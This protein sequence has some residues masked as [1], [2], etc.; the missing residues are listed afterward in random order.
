MTTE[1]RKAQ[2]RASQQRYR[3]RK[4]RQQQKSPIFQSVTDLPFDQPRDMPVQAGDRA[5]SASVPPPD[6]STLDGHY[7][8]ASLRL[9]PAGA[10]CAPIAFMPGPQLI[11]DH[12]SGS[13]KPPNMTTPSEYERENSRDRTDTMVPS[14]RRVTTSSLSCR[15]CH[16]YRR[17]YLDV[18][19]CPGISGFLFQAKARLLVDL[20][21]LHAILYRSGGKRWLPKYRR[22][23][24]PNSR[25]TSSFLI[26]KF[27]SSEAA[28]LRAQ[29]SDAFGLPDSCT[30]R[31][32]PLMSGMAV[33]GHY[34]HG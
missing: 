20:T 6:S 31:F 9:G 25:G 32:F 28:D 29:I 10:R 26:I 8:E 1:K 23:A 4:R 30:S 11:A 27:P 15:L 14:E 2:N 22:Q 5:R 17:L 3:D 7:S 18:K 12:S 19:I 16:V 21:T 33:P 34:S 24:T 13:P